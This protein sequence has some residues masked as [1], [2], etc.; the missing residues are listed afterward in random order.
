MSS[1]RAVAARPA[2]FVAGLLLTYFVASLSQ[3]L[4]IMAALERAGAA[5][6]FVTRVKVVGHDLVGLT[7]Y[8]D[9]P[10]S[11]GA[12]LFIGLMIALVAAD[13]L[14]RWLPGART[15]L[16]AIAGAAAVATVLWI[17]QVTFFYHMSLLEGTR[18]AFGYSAQLVA[19]ALGGL[20]YARLS[21]RSGK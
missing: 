17:I 2:A 11:Y 4:F 5:F 19:G 3:S 20:C 7:F 18:G 15:V 16:C 12:Q 6:D 14:G 8:A 13:S 21:S 1:I 10:I 9:M